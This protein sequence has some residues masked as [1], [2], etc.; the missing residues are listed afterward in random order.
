MEEIDIN[1]NWID[2]FE[3]N[4]KDYKQFYKIKPSKIKLFLLYVDR[5]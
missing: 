3:C 4:D 2:E 5:I 1:T